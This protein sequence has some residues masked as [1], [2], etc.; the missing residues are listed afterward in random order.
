MSC[1]RGN[2]NRTRAQKHQNKTAFKN[3]L[4]DSSKKTKFLNTLQVT[5][6]CLRC[7]EI[8]E[9]KI[10]YKKYKPLAAPKKCV[11]CDQRTVKFAYHVL[12]NNCSAEKKVC[13]KCVKA[14]ESTETT[15]EVNVD[16]DKIKSILKPLSERKRR[17]ILRYINKQEKITDETISNIEDILLE[18]DNININDCNNSNSSIVDSS[19]DDGDDFKVEK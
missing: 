18:M 5:G 8:I 19:S 16:E 13:A 3:D 11:G 1:S 17:A 12:C 10:K 9:W 4:H 2:T 7:K 6:V 14:M 15:I